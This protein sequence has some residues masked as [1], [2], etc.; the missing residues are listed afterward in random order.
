MARKRPANGNEPRW[1]QARQ[2]KAPSLEWCS[3]HGK[4]PKTYSIINGRDSLRISPVQVVHVRTLLNRKEKDMS[5]ATINMPPTVTTNTGRDKVHWSKEVW[6]RI[7]MA[8]HH[9]VMRTRVAE[10]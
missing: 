3:P 10:H 7:D 6:D 1:L 2:N 9:E 8:V 4:S 5:T